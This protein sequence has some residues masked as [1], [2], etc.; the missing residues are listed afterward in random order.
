LDRNKLS[1]RWSCRQEHECTDRGDANEGAGCRNPESLLEPSNEAVDRVV[2]GVH[3]EEQLLFDE[4]TAF[5]Q[6][7]CQNVDVLVAKRHP[8]T[9]GVV[10]KEV[11]ERQ[12]PVEDVLSSCGIERQ[13]VRRGGHELVVEIDHQSAALGNDRSAVD[14]IERRYPSDQ[15]VGE[16]P[17]ARFEVAEFA[18]GEGAARRQVFEIGSGAESGLGEQLS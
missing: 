15:L 16:Q 10:T 17:V 13:C 18:Y 3:G 1:G 14:L 6:G 8:S 12:V 2:V 11:D 7:R 9:R 5:C 4:F